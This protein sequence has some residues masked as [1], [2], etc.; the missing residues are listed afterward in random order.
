ALRGRR[1]DTSPPSP[2]SYPGLPPGA[3]AVGAAPTSR[4]LTTAPLPVAAAEVS[5]DGIPDIITTNYGANTVSVLLGNG[6]GSFQS[7]QTFNVGMGPDSVAVADVNGDGRPDII[8]ANYGSHS[9][10]VLL[11]NGDGSFHA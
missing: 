4:A 8:T 7:Q 1:D 6:D 11:G 5:G 3:F 2:F 9:V 10:S